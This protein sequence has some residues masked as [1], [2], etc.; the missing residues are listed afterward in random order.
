MPD[1]SFTGTV[2]RIAEEAEF[3]PKNVQTQDA[4]AQLV[5]AVEISINNTDGVFKIG[6]PADAVL[7]PEG[8]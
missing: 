8:G 3:T 4:R 5:Y 2:T 6:M 1:T 7:V